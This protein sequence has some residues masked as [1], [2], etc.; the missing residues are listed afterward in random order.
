MK[1]DR[2]HLEQNELADRLNRWWK[3]T[4]EARSSS[5]T[6]GIIGAAL[7]VV[8]LVIA[9]RYFSESGSRAQAEVWPQI[10]DASAKGL[11]AIAQG[12]SGTTVGHIAK[13]EF[14]RMKLNDGLNKLSS[15]FTRSEGIG[16]VVEARKAYTELITEARGD[17]PLVREAMLGAA[18][19]E[20][21]LVG[22]PES[23]NPGQ[24]RGSLDKALELYEQTAKE[25]D[26]TP[27][28][29]QAVAR[30]KDIRENKAKIQQMYDDLNR[31][32]APIDSTPR[33]SNADLPFGHPPIPPSFGP[34]VAPNP[35]EPMK[36]L[37]APP[38]EPAPKTQKQP[39]DKPLAPPEKS[40]DEKTA[41]ATKPADSK[42]LAPPPTPDKSQA[43]GKPEAK[44]SD[45]PDK[46]KGN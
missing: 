32:F 39:D 31:R 36:P 38:G 15:Q 3:G 40:K 34:E 46:S 9:W 7:L 5:A 20:E 35:A 17:A 44:P 27:Q 43:P 6:W 2:K 41:P 28:G 14:A 42:P 29:N 25:F 23:D 4:G 18:Q 33:P 13:A 16:D 37:A 21:S 1:A 19:A 11:A 45:K 30:A 24:S 26:K 8:V 12:N 22:I 10:E